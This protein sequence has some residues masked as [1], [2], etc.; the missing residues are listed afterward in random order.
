MCAGSAILRLT[1]LALR[2]ARWRQEPPPLHPPPVALWGIEPHRTI[3]DVSP[4]HH[5]QG[6]EICLPLFHAFMLLLHGLLFRFSADLAFLSAVH[7]GGIGVLCA[8]THFAHTAFTAFAFAIFTAI[9][10]AS[11]FATLAFLATWHLHIHARLR[12]A[13][14]VC[15]GRNK[16]H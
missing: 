2:S 12:A 16:Q 1:S 7:R 11:I 10:A 13:L 15:T 8:H 3:E 9:S 14:C 5:S 4:L 6:L